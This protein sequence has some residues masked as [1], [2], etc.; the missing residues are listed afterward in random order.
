MSDKPIAVGDLVQVVRTC[1]NEFLKGPWIF[2]VAEI[3]SEPEA[4]C[5]QCSKD[6]P[7]GAQARGLTGHRVGVPLPWLRR[8]PPLSELE[9]QQT[10]E[11]LR[12]PR[13]EPQHG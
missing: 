6:V 1:C 3:A 4:F 12:V 10:Q 8:I 13:K 2:Q 7:G 9:G 5:S 11:P